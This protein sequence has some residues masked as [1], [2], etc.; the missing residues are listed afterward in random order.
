MTCHFVTM[1]YKT[2]LQT[3][4]HSTPEK[5]GSVITIIKRSVHIDLTLVL[6]YIKKRG[7]IIPL[8]P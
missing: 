5:S 7:K 6:N 1:L 8:S 4:H 3:I 2:S